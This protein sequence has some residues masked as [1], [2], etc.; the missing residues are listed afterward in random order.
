[1]SIK[2]DVWIKQMCREQG[3]IEPFE[4]RLVREVDGRRIISCGLSSY[5][6]DCRLA[7]DEF[8]V[9]SPVTGTEIDPKNFDPH[10]LLDVPLRRSSEGSD[11][12]LLPPHSYALGVTIERFNMPRNVTALAIGKSTYARCFRGDTRVALVD[13]TAPTLEEMARRADDGELLWGY[14]LGENGRLIVTLLDAPR[15]IGRDALMAVTLDN[16]ETIHCTPDHKFIVRDGRSVQACDLRP[17]NPL[18]PLYRQLAR[19]YEVIYQPINGHWVPTHRLADEWNVRNGIYQDAPGTHRHQVDG[20]RRNNVPF[21][22]VR[23]SPS[24]HIRYHNKINYGLDFNPQEHSE[25]IRAA[26]ARLREDQE[27][28]KQFR[29]MQQQK[30]LRFWNEPAYHEARARWIEMHKQFW[31]EDARQQQSERQERFW[32]AHPERREGVSLKSKQVWA[33]ASQ[34]RREQQQCIARQMNT[35]FEITEEVVRAALDETGSIRGAARLLSC[36]RTVFRRFPDVIRAFRGQHPRN[37]KVVS[38]SEVKGDH[39]VYCLTVPEAGNFALEAGVF[40][41]NCGLMANTTP[42]EAAW[43][44]R[45]VVELYNAAN[46]PVRLYAEEGF[47]QILFFE[48]DEE[49]ETTYSD[50]GGKYQD[51]QG[52]TLAKV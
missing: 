21:N 29:E 35:R 15:Y 50:R 16:G 39:D 14:S 37:H 48:S 49:C 3:L 13:G 33:S 28:D 4:E 2:S 24:E 51:Q 52:L 44:G 30:A 19:G 10:S 26:L 17:G 22:I 11:Y 6:Y 47:I 1:M 18:M 7:R 5:G 20:R 38:V 45:L 42:L 8:K 34:E 41:H 27:W 32:Q 25:S 43:C 9:F 36:D 31:T 40:V 46:L 23:M 12:W